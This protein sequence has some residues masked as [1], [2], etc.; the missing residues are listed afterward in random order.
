MGRSVEEGR[1]FE[2]CSIG[3]DIVTGES[4]HRS[5]EEMKQTFNVRLTNQDCGNV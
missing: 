4:L 3:A 5:C 1:V 2:I